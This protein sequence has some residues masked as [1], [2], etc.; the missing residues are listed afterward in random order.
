MGVPKKNPP[1][2]FGYVPGCLNP[3]YS[4]H[5]TPSSDDIVDVVLADRQTDD[6]SVD[7]LAAVLGTELVIVHLDPAERAHREAYR[8]ATV[9]VVDTSTQPTRRR[10]RGAPSQSTTN[11]RAAPFSTNDTNLSNAIA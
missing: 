2:F 3:D 7:G 4:T 5:I 1:G 8:V 9:Q 11:N 10:L 6:A